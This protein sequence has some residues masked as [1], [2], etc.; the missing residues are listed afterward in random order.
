MNNLFATYV[1][2]DEMVKFFYQLTLQW[3]VISFLSND[4]HFGVEE[5]LEEALQIPPIP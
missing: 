3:Y 2:D 1:C 5:A 4:S